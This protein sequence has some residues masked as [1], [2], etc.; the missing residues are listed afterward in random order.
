[1]PI[2]QKIKNDIA[3]VYSNLCKLYDCAEGIF[4]GYSSD[5]V[6]NM[7][8]DIVVKCS[9]VV[10]KSILEALVGRGRHRSTDLSSSSF[11]FELSD[12]A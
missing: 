4:S 6:F 11:L 5:V 9:N 7:N 8:E 12:A 10:T 1:M 3:V 2:S